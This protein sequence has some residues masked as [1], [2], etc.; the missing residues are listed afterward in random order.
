MRRLVV[1]AWLAAL[2]A[3]S[4]KT[5][6]PAPP[7]PAPAAATT[8]PAD[9]SAGRCEVTVS[10]DV[11]ATGVSGGG[12]QAVGTDYWMSPAD[13]EASIQRFAAERPEA[14]R[15]AAIA[16][17]KAR[18]PYQSVLILNCASARVRITLNP[19]TAATY[20]DIP[21]AAGTYTISRKNDKPSYF[22]AMLMVDGE[23][24]SLPNDQDGAIEIRKFD[25][26][27]IA[28]TFSFPAER[29]D[30]KTKAVAKVT[31]KGTFD[32][33]CSYPTSV[34]RGG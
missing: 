17:A 25:R 9:T 23:A 3:C 1:A 30:Y 10:G 24:Y 13:I 16:E 28:G 26:T 33:T 11:Q 7:A 19:G 32:F 14:E 6:A 12:A 4:S 8:P 31:V 5:D 22:S 2:A 29:T 15:A 27:G 34:C 20:A 21:F 18:D